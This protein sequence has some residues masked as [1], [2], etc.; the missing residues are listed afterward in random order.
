MGQERDS[1][2]IGL[3]A[4]VHGSQRALVQPGLLKSVGIIWTSCSN[5]D[6]DSVGLGWGF[7]LQ[8]LRFL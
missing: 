8:F 4:G 2:G 3:W 1:E 7:R 5:G 6:S